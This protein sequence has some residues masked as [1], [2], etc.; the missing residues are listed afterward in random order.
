ME[1]KIIFLDTSIFESENYFEGK[2]INI[3][4]NL[5]EQN[6][7]QIKLTEIVYREILN[8]IENHTTKAI[9]LYKKEKLN[10]EREARILR[11]INVLNQQFE[12]VD[13]KQLKEEA[14]SQIISKLNELISKYNIEI[15]NSNIINV[16]E[17]INDYFQTNPPFKDGLKKNE[18]PDAININTI[19]KWSENNTVS[20]FY[21]S[22]DK[23]FAN[24]KNELI[25]CTHNLPSI[26]EYLYIENDQVQYEFI[27]SIFEKS[28]FEIK[29]QIERDFTEDLNS[30]AFSEL[31]NDAFYEDV[32]CDF[33]EINNIE[34]NIG[35]INEIDD[36]IFSYEIELDI[37]FSVE[38]Y[39]TDLSMAYY[40]REDGVWWGEERVSQ[41]KKYKVNTL[42]Y[43][44]FEIE[45]NKTDGNFIEITDFDFRNLEEIE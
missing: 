2:N 30:L 4:F 18:F 3:L 13:F 44:D 20:C 7:I 33:L 40:D 23:D 36:E 32:E 42:I 15:V 11:N 26:L 10:F 22:N 35:T 12:K 43:A 6:L 19:K 25:D 5:A 1:N 16:D 41:I 34:I 14:K 29:S 24:Y 21:I 31:E 45:D 17:I 37:I 8:R 27:T 39:Y 28:I 38:A 9:N